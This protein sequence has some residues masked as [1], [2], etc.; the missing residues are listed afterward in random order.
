VTVADASVSAGDELG[1][2][3]HLVVEFPEGVIAG[4]GFEVL[5]G[6]VEAHV[7]FVLDLEFVRAEDDGSVSLVD[8]R[9]LSGSGVDLT[10][11]EGASSGLLDEADL[12]LVGEGLAPGSVAAVLVYEHLDAVAL[13][14]GMRRGGGR[15]ISQ[16][17]VPVEDLEAAF[18]TEKADG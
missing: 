11:F 13:A 4:D 12:R 17:R 10:A 3:D 6:L 14:A 18:D 8:V 16:S 1:P 5:L 15:V 9:E 7:V 2:V